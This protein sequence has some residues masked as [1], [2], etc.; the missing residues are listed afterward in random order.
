MNLSDP[1]P[2]PTRAKPDGLLTPLYLVVST[3]PIVTV[4]ATAPALTLTGAVCAA[5]KPVSDPVAV[6]WSGPNATA[7]LSSTPV[8]AEIAMPPSDTDW[9][10]YARTARIWP[11][12]ELVS[13]KFWM[14]V[15]TYVAIEYPP[16]VT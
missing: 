14:F 4:T 1:R 13:G 7:K 16:V 11:D 9:L 2:G 6:K 3:A 8:H 15:A 10:R 12:T 5:K